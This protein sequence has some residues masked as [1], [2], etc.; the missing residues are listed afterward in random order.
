MTLES[1]QII[2]ETIKSIGS[3]SMSKSDF[4]SLKL[5][6]NAD[7]NDFVVEHR[8][9][10]AKDAAAVYDNKTLSESQFQAYITAAF[11]DELTFR[12][13]FGI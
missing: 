10:S 5:I 4:D 13:A 12:T 2:I 1:S 9:W 8:Y 11:E 6:Y 7:S 3:V